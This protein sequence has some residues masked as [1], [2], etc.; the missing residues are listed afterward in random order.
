[1]KY[2]S[3]IVVCLLLFPQQA[4]AQIRGVVVST[5]TGNP[6]RDVVVS[7]DREERT[8][9]SW[10]GSFALCDTAF[11]EVTFGNLHYERR[12]MFK[13]ELTDTILLIP[14][15]Q[16]LGEVVVIGKARRKSFNQ[17]FSVDKAELK[18]LDK[19]S[20]NSGTFSM[21]EM[22]RLKKKKKLEHL[23]KVLTNY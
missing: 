4:E 20:P 2:K 8:V 7:T 22:M 9:T 5:E 11:H 3:S 10:D 16:A 15:I 21:G 6:V 13:E 12:T 14:N 17:R 18:A 19:A 1:M 23:K